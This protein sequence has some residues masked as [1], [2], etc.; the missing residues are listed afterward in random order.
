LRL[1]CK[2]NQYKHI[3]K[4]TV[5][6]PISCNERGKKNMNKRNQGSV[7]IAEKKLLGIDELTSFLSLGRNQAREFGVKAGAD[8][9]IGGRVLYDREA[10]ERYVDSLP[11]R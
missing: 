1:I 8:R 9:R 11:N 7:A 2:I 4:S 6:I 5:D 3:Q 10:I